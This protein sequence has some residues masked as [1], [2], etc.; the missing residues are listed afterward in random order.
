MTTK[1]ATVAI[2]I[3]LAFQAEAILAQSAAP[4]RG[5]G[6]RQ[7]ERGDLHVEPP[8]SMTTDERN[9]LA[10]SAKSARSVDELQSRV[11]SACDVQG[12][13]FAL[14]QKGENGIVLDRS[15]TLPQEKVRCIYFAVSNSSYYVATAANRR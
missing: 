10:Y 7:A 1:A 9:R 2:T 14:K 3:L 6:T 5:F 15:P 4:N 13:Q 8:P 12:W 11:A